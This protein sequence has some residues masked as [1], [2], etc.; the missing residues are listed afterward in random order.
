[1]DTKHDFSSDNPY[2]HFDLIDLIGKGSYGE[3]FKGYSKK[4][5]KTVAIKIIQILENEGG[6]ESIRKEIEILQDCKHQ[7]IIYY[8]GSYLREDVMWIIMEVKDLI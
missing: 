5:S 6:F 2:E 7:N 1:M 8:I 3:V 4:D